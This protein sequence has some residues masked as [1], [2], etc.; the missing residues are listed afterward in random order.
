LL[1]KIGNLAPKKLASRPDTT[2]RPLKS[3]IPLEHGEQEWNSP[4]LDLSGCSDDDL[5]QNNV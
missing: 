5:D 2:D 4:V 1:V 3:K